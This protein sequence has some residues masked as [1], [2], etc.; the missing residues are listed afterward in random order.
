MPEQRHTSPRGVGLVGAGYWA[1]NVARVIA[2]HPGSTLR[3]VC[4]VDHDRAQTLAAR[5]GAQAT[6]TVDDLLADPAVECI[7]VVTPPHTHHALGRAALLAGKHV[8]VEKPLTMSTVTAA[9]LVAVA[10]AQQR[11]LMVGHTFL[12]SPA[13]LK[14]KELF[15]TGAIGDVH[16]IDSQRVNLGRYQDS[17]VLWDL[18]PHDL[19]ILGYWLGEMPV[20]AT[21]TGRSYVSPGYED[22]AFVTLEYPSGVVAQLHLSWL[23]PA[24]LRRTTVAGSRRMVVYDDTAG[25]EAVKVF[26]MGVVRPSDATAANGTISYRSGDTLIPQLT[27]CEP[28]AAQ[29]DHFLE[30][31][32]TGAEPR[33]SGRHGLKVVAALEAIATAMRT[34]TRTTVSPLLSEVAA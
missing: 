23:A 4:D 21:A 9:D 2:G 11:T 30:C 14:V 25:P 27:S 10:Q 18:G 24:R 12:Y 17:G 19:S 32:R 26:D 29:W 8:I 33:T 13:V 1:A 15:T 5:S 6:G 34:G 3:W 20:A 7:Y 28:L 31:V 16:Y 22:V